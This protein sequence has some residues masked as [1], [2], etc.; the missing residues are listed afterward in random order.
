VTIYY[1]PYKVI[2]P[3]K[4]NNFIILCD[5]AS[6]N[7]P[8]K[9]NKLG[10]SSY[11]LKKHIGWDIGALKVAKKISKNI[12]NTLIHSGYSRL[13]IDCNRSLKSQGSF[14]TK[15]EDIEIPG[16]YNISRKEK[17][18][19]SKRYYF[20]YH[21]QIKKFINQSLKSGVVPSL[22]A[23]HSFTPVY[24]G[25]FR[26]W[27]VGILQRSDKRL[28]S[29]FIKDIKKNKK[30][31]LGINEPYKLDLPGDFTIP[32]FSE[33]YGLPNVLIEIR[34]DLLLKDKSINYWSNLI[35]KILMRNS[36]NNSLKYCLKPSNRISKYYQ[37]RNSL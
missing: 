25:K 14:L 7:I 28:S 4:K 18:L 6:Y 8:K 13:L 22:V 1:Q 3:Q 12:N 36:K 10:L 34:Q 15:S 20:P 11:N 21:N 35:T 31:I 9:Y 37:E 27:H 24:H 29:L 16:N 2:N 32:F 30:I 17:I 26:K 5:H 19:R 23:I 33:S